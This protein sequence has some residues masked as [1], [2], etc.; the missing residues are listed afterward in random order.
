MVSS[1]SKADKEVL[2]YKC[3]IIEYTLALF[4][5]YI[6]QYSVIPTLPF[7]IITVA[8]A[9]GLF[10]LSELLKKEWI[11]YFY[12]VPMVIYMISGVL[13]SN[14]NTIES[15][16]PSEFY[17]HHTY[18][19]NQTDN[20][21]F[22]IEIYHCFT[23]SEGAQSFTEGNNHLLIL[24]GNYKYSPKEVANRASCKST[25]A[26]LQVLFDEA[27]EIPAMHSK[28]LSV[29]LISAIILIFIGWIVALKREYKT[30]DKTRYNTSSIKFGR[31]SFFVS[32]ALLVCAIIRCVSLCGLVGSTL[33]THSDKS[34]TSQALQSV[35][36]RTFSSWW[37]H[38]TLLINQ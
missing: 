22:G 26:E 5:T 15:L 11:C 35:A 36:I 33:F 1:S 38:D 10:E 19:F 6:T 28:T 34:V 31:L 14:R 3:L 9:I 18:N 8:T 29:I 13:E 16:A 37:T 12:L 32:S 21:P 25:A 17:G 20:T 23:D 4:L 7:S 30:R 24:G 2:E 27:D